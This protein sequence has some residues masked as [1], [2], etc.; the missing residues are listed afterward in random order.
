MAS[1]LAKDRYAANPA[2]RPAHMSA[3]LFFACWLALVSGCHPGGGSTPEPI[4]PPESG[5]RQDPGALVPVIPYT[6]D[7]DLENA[8]GSV[9]PSIAEGD[10]TAGADR[11]PILTR[12]QQKQANQA[13]ASLGLLTLT[14]LSGHVENSKEVP[15]LVLRVSIKNQTRL[16]IQAFQGVLVL[17]DGQGPETRIPMESGRRLAPGE[18]R[19]GTWRIPLTDPGLSGLRVGTDEPEGRLR[20][21]HFLPERIVFEKGDTWTP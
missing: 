21:G 14:P 7:L 3:R 18:N 9:T 11:N 13:I 15:V 19:E 1:I 16:A 5:V 10:R 17:A 4:S 8:P 20:K 6:T 2:Y 12:T